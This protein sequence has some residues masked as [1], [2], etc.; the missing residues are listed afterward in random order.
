MLQLLNAFFTVQALHVAAAG[1]LREE[2]DGRFSLTALGATLRSDGPD[3]VRDWALYVGA[4]APWEAWGRLRDTVM[5]GEPG[6]VLAHG[7]PTYDYLAQNPELGAT[8]D[9]WMPRQSDQHNAAVVAG[10]DFSP[11]RTLADIGGG[12]PSAAGDPGRSA[13][14]DTD[15][16]SRRS[17]WIL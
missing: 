3:S 8:F 11:F 7:M 2:A 13:H 5:T 17:T 6:F 9:R 1:A 16:L 4:P 15:T 12:R 10:Y 14:S